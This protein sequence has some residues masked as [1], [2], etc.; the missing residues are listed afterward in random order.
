MATVQDFI[1]RALKKIGATSEGETPTTETYNDVLATLNDMLAEWNS[2]GININDGDLVLTDTWPTDAEDSRAVMH[3]LAIEIG[4]E[5]GAIPSQTV[6]TIA[7]E[8]YNRA[9]AKYMNVPDATID[10]ALINGS[11]NYNILTD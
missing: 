1:K 5:F 2:I 9:K 6:Y 10:L 11:S 7:R 3:N 8:S 4:P